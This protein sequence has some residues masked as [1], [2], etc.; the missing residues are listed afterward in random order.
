VEVELPDNLTTWRVDAKGV[1]V[2]T[3]VGEATVDVV[4]TKELLVR[5][6]AP[7]FFVMGDEAR[8][9]AVVHNNGPSELEVEV[10]LEAVGARVAGEAEQKLRVPAGGREKVTWSAVVETANEVKLTFS[11]RGGKLSD[12]VELTLP[13][14]HFSTPETVAT[15]GQ[16]EDIVLETIRLPA[17]VDA[18]LGE[19]TVQVEPSLA[20][21]ML[22]GLNYLRAYPYDCTEQTVSRFLPNVMTFRA[23]Q[24]L[25]VQ[26]RELEANL[27]QSVGVGLQRLYKLQ[28]FDGGWGWWLSDASD[29]YITAYV[30][31][32]MNEAHRAGFSVDEYTMVRASEFLVDFLDRGTDVESPHSLDTRAFILYVLAESGYGDLGRA[33]ALYQRR[34]ALQNYG[35]AYLAMALR[36]LA[37]ESDARA[38]NL[39]NSL[40][41][42]AIT[43]ATGAHWE[44][45]RV[46]YWT[47]NT[48]TR[49]TAIVL[50]ALVRLDPENPL[51]PNAV[52]WLMTARREG[53]WET[54]QETAMSLI[55]LTDYLAASGDLLADYSYQVSLNG[56]EMGG[57]T[58]NAENLADPKRLVVEIADLLLDADN[59]VGI[60][61]KVRGDQTGKGNLWYSMYLRYF[62]PVDEVRS[63]SRGVTIAKEYFLLGEEG[64]RVHEAQVGDVIQA[65]ITI[66]AP[67][68]LHYLVVEDPLPAG[69]EALDASLKTTS[70][71]VQRPRL[72]RQDDDRGSRTWYFSE[73]ALRD[74]KAVLFATYLP[75]GV[76]EYTYLIRAGVA[77]KFHVMPAHAYEMYFPEVFGR[78]DG[79]LFTIE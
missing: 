14:Y 40:S 28:H 38:R 76:Y 32:G 15:S 49:S 39:V 2:D 13:A 64:R 25:G 42:S 46:D 37:A 26:N 34:E 52:R 33:A 8:L 21:G 70:V 59:E 5:P 74:E 60:H 23:L 24:E 17:T 51:I 9:E 35:R 79:S 68:D 36:L 63:L 53:H 75:Q 78:S 29:P 3:L 27:P 55:A 50:D 7:R 45:D 30:L 43:S 54:T 22:D 16:V 62:L 41:S 10:S 1:T 57:D 69:C 12:A 6:V 67:N 65:K 20:A 72:K 58:V 44:E 77:G 31:L 4:S 18:E 61:R 71:M 56:E 66:I 73:T 11:A 47:M 48:N 19:L